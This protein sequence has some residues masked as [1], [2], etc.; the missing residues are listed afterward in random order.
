MWTSRFKQYSI[1][2]QQEIDVSLAFTIPREYITGHDLTCA[3]LFHGGIDSPSINAYDPLIK[4]P[5]RITKYLCLKSKICTQQYLNHLHE[6]ILLTSDLSHPNIL[7][8]IHYVKQYKRKNFR[9]NAFLIF[10]N[11]LFKERFI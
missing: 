5:V 10:R 6:R 1:A 8:R 7:Y 2:H 9:S 3:S 4:Q 11:R